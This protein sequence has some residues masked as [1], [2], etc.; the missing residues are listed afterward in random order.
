VQGTGQVIIAP[1]AVIQASGAVTGGGESGLILPQ[2]MLTKP[3]IGTDPNAYHSSDIEAYYLAV[4]QDQVGYVRVSN[5]GLTTLNVNPT[6]SGFPT[7]A[8]D[9]DQNAYVLPIYATNNGSLTIGA[10]A[11]LISN[12]S[13]LL[14]A[15]ATGTV[16]AGVKLA[17]GMLE[18]RSGTTIS[19]GTSSAPTGIVVDQG[20]LAAL[21]GVRKLILMSAGEIDLYG[22]LNLG[23]LDPGGQLVV[24]ALDVLGTD[25]SG[26]ATGYNNAQISL[27]SGAVTVAGFG[28]V[29]LKSSG[30]ILVTGDGG[31]LAVESQLTLNTPR[32]SGGCRNSALRRT[33]SAPSTIRPIRAATMRSVSSTAAAPPLCPPPC[34]ATA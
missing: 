31:S 21:G 17:T 29:Y 2:M 18:V 23:R 32:I 1:N 24:N 15:N 27:G 22:N 19:L 11:Q 9:V 5:G 14:Y 4:A 33:P 25:P 12:N 34:L 7:G 13:I 28:S 16:A 6:F 20:A 8:A 10:G 3:G 26:A 30:Q